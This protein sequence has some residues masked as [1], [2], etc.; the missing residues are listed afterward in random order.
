MK[1]LAKIFGTLVS[2][3]AG[4]LGAKLVSGIWHKV[5]RKSVV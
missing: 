5:D 4:W 3:G 2:L 1:L